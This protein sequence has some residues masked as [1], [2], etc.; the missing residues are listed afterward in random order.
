MRIAIAQVEFRPLSTAAFEDGREET[1]SERH[2]RI[3]EWLRSHAD[4]GPFDLVVLPELWLPGA[5]DYSSW[6]EDAENPENGDLISALGDLARE[7]GALIHAGSIIEPGVPDASGVEPLFNTSVIFDEAGAVAAKYRKIHRFGHG[8][9]ESAVLSAGRDAEILDLVMDG[10]DFTCGLATCYDL[11]FPELFR[12]YQDMGVNAFVIPA[13]WPAARIAHWDVL[14]QARAI[15]NQ[16]LVI[17]CNTAGTD[18]G[19]TLGGHSAIIAPDGEVLARAGDGEEF[20]VIDYDPA[21]IERTR[22]AFPVLSD[23]CIGVSTP[24][25]TSTVTVLGGMQ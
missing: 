16:A 9:G 17:A 10:H 22:A 5:W 20:L 6:R 21:D 3:L 2:Q 13:S 25:A 19:V 18:S 11:R 14:L 4:Q 12:E 24:A 23:R 7:W 8:G 15:E 1:P